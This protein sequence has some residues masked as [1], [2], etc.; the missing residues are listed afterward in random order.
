MAAALAALAGCGEEVDE[1]GAR[2][3]WEKIHAEGYESWQRAPG[4]DQ[5]QPTVRAH[6][7]TA[8]VYVNPTVADA[9]AGPSLDAWP[10]GAL[11]V[12][13][14]FEGDEKKLVAAMEKQGSAW[15]FA[16]WTPSGDA[17]YASEPEVCTNCHAAGN[18]SVLAVALP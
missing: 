14:S 3:L 11:L 8:L 6:G 1:E 2:A 5:P 16:E 12:K 15:F 9:V 7:Q 17:K 4:Y 13:D 18:D 10:E